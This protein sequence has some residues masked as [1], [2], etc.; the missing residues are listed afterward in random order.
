MILD[1]LD[2]DRALEDT[3]IDLVTEEGLDVL[4]LIGERIQN[5]D[6]PNIDRL[7][8]SLVGDALEVLSERLCVF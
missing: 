6:D 3:T 1:A 7:V 5:Q 2:K 4:A 8:L